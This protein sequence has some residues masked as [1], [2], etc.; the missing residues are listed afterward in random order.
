MAPFILIMRQHENSYKTEFTTGQHPLKVNAR[1][2]VL[3]LKLN[4]GHQGKYTTIVGEKT[5]TEIALR[6][7][8]LRTATR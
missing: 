1:S 6:G 4:D 7:S 3:L 8:L 2:L 5:P